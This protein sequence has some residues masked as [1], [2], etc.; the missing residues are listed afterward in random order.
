MSHRKSPKASNPKV[1]V[2]KPKSA[3]PIKTNRKGG[4]NINQVMCIIAIITAIIALLALLVAIL[5][6]VL[7]R[8][9]YNGR[10]EI[11]REKQKS[12]IEATKENIM[13]SIRII[14]KDIN[15]DDI[16]ENLFVWED[17]RLIR[18]YEL[19]LKNTVTFFN[20]Y[21]NTPDLTTFKNKDL[22]E[23]R[24]II[25]KRR[26]KIIDYLDAIKY[27]CSLV[28][29]INIYGINHDI[30]YYKVD[31][32]RWDIICDQIDLWYNTR[33]SAFQSSI[34]YIEDLKKEFIVNPTPEQIEEMFK[35]F[36]ELKQ[37]VDC[38][39]FENS[40]FEYAI[41]LDKCYRITLNYKRLLPVNNYGSTT[42]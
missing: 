2:N 24:S 32:G 35:P 21:D 14:E 8:K 9:D 1:G 11:E 4:I 34:N 3:S 10:K 23:I 12:E 7:S 28:G 31:Q 39:K 22:I 18:N 38:Y 5:Q 17:V 6:Y 30:N 15:V 33:D 26:E 27:T 25:Q 36:D 16:P 20:S 37:N 29:E 42:N 19:S 41:E 40:F 13:N